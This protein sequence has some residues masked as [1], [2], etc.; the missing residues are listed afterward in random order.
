VNSSVIIGAEKDADG[1]FELVQQD[2]LLVGIG[3]NLYIR[4]SVESGGKPENS[5]V[6]A[7]LVSHSYLKCDPTTRLSIIPQALR[8]D[9]AAFKAKTIYDQ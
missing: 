2:K 9:R 7:V 3:G 6:Q 8:S 1:I 4:Q 5:F